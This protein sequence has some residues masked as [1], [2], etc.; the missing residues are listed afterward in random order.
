MATNRAS[1]SPHDAFAADPDITASDASNAAR[2]GS[3]PAEV[4]TLTMSGVPT[5]GTFKLTLLGVT[6]GTIPYNANAAAIK[7]VI[8]TA[9]PGNTVAVGG[10]ARST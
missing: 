2:L 10:T 9:I 1:A 5:G 8:D 4:Q 7:A 6:T 3:L